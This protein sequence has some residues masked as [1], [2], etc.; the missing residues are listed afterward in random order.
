MSGSGEPNAVSVL[1]A[2]R[3]SFHD[4]LRADGLLAL[5]TSGIPSMSDKKNGTSVLLGTKLLASLGPV[6][7]RPR[8]S[9]QTAGSRFEARIRTFLGEIFPHLAPLRCGTFAVQRGKAIFNYDQ[10]EHLQRLASIASKED[11]EELR[12]VLGSDYLV[13]P[14]VVVTRAAETDEALN[15]GPVMLVDAVTGRRSSIRAREGRLPTLHASISCKWTMRSDRA[16]N[17]RSEALNLIRNRKGRLPHIAVVTAEADPAII[18]SLA[19]GT[20]DLDCVYHIALDELAEA[21]ESFPVSN[22]T[23]LFRDMVSGHRLRDIA[24]LPLDLTV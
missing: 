16:Q 6:E 19:L 18:A 1:A 15:G 4:N 20:A 12:V 11:M 24:D 21:V 2:A 9:G 7:V 3:R 14:D 8:L 17:A 10:Y 23:R 22:A 5:N 13:K